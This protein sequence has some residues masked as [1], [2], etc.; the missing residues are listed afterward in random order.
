MPHDTN[1]VELKQGDIVTIQM[2][3]RAVYPGAEMCNVTLVRGGA[4]E[5]ALSL[6]CQARQVTKIGE[7]S[8]V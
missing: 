1:G 5:Q 2:T 8:P 3:V 6:T 7:V 4:D